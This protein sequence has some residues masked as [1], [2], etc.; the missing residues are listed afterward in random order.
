MRNLK[1]TGS[2][3]LMAIMAGVIAMTGCVTSSTSNRD[4]FAQR[5][6]NVFDP[7]TID[8]VGD[9]VADW[10]LANLDDLSY[11]RNSSDG[12]YDQRGWIQGAL[13]VGLMNWAT[14]PGNDGYDAALRE[15]AEGNEW[16]LGDRLFHGD[17]HVVGQ[18]YLHFYEKEQDRAM[19]DHA[20]LQF[21]QILMVQPDGTLEFPGDWVPGLG[22]PCQL[23]WCW[24][25]ALFMSPPT[26]IGLSLATGD[27]RYMEYGDKEFWATT[28]YLL[29][30]E[31]NLFYRDSRYFTMRDEEGNKIFWARGNGWVYAGLVNILRVL[32]EEHPSRPRY[33]EL[34]QKM[35]E[36]IASIQQGN[37]LWRV[38]LLAKEEYAAPETS[39]SSFLTYGLAWGL[40]NG[41][42]DADTFG[43]VVR[44]GW[45]ALVNAVDDEGKLG[46]VQPVGSA[47]DSVFATDS[48]L[49]GVGAFLLAASQVMQLN[50]VDRE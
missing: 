45:Q 13:F 29:D 6:D 18:L 28:D 22:M 5:T 9:A 42:L 14:L 49:Y 36:T 11:I 44:K 21:N 46:W 30:P 25:D 43:P 31:Y 20:I 37:G 26:W 33:M 7:L 24:C 23:R 15:I 34:F 27:D 17:D 38:S 32:P 10:Q 19:L 3:Q 41:H 35:S 16:R 2:Q 48:H 50:Q 4:L 12:F 8:A 1:L 47:P 40:N 39:G